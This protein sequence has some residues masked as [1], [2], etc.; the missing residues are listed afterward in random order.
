MSDKVQALANRIAAAVLED[1]KPENGGCDISGGMFG[2]NFSTIVRELAGAASRDVA[3]MVERLEAMNL[4]PCREAAAM[5]LQ[6]AA[7]LAALSAP[8]KA[9]PVPESENA[10]RI[11]TK[12]RAKDLSVHAWMNI[13]RNQGLT[14]TETLEGMVITLSSD[15][16]YFTSRGRGAALADAERG[17][18]AHPPRRT[19][20]AIVGQVDGGGYL[21]DTSDN[22]R[23]TI[24]THFPPKVGDDV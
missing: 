12:L 14:W 19:I 5:L 13:Q 7:Q 24:K 22:Q 2:P 23:F 16:A 1:E 3:F 9:V 11:K 15:K 4:N 17:P 8:A 6:Q 10:V 21:V 20:V 18:I